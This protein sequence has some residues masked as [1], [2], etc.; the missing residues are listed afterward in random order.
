VEIYPTSNLRLTPKKALASRDI[1][2]E[3]WLAPYITPKGLE[4]LVSFKGVK[5]EGLGGP[6]AMVITFRHVR[7]GSKSRVD[8]YII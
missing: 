4:V 5:F 7:N 2:M 8:V 1:L 3:I 6:P